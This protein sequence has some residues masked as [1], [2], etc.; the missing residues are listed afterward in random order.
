MTDY[1]GA[2]WRKST[3]SMGSGDCVE[4]SELPSGEV[5]LRD[6]KDQAGPVLVFGPGEWGAFVSGLRGRELD[7]HP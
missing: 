2:R 5:A 7:F 3:Y 1:C 4:F 6:S